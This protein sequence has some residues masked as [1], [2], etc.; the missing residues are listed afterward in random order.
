MTCNTSTCMCKLSFCR[1]AC[2]G[3][4]QSRA[5]RK[6]QYTNASSTTN[7]NQHS[8]FQRHIT[9][10]FCA[11]ST[12]P[13][14]PTQNNYS[15]SRIGVAVL[16]LSNVWNL[17]FSVFHSTF[18]CQSGIPPIKMSKSHSNRGNFLLHFTIKISV[19]PHPAKQ[20]NVGPSLYKIGM[21]W[22]G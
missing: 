11:Q 7:M 20:N 15:D 16:S 2:I 9:Q 18:Y 4:L 3:S 10:P 5:E 17:W 8:L 21:N 22:S 6:T 12:H 13:L 1:V 19:L 14:A